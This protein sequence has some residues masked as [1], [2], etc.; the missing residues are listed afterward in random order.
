[1]RADAAPRADAPARA[2]G[3]RGVRAG[4]SFMQV[5]ISPARRVDDAM[6]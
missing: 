6:K 5:S 1:M 4:K 3:A 2:S